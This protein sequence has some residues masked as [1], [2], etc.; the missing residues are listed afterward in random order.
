MIFQHYL[1]I[2]KVCDK[3]ESLASRKAIFAVKL[4]KFHSC[5][6]NILFQNFT[7][8]L[9]PSPLKLKQSVSVKLGKAHLVFE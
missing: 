3:I 5:D 6:V 8:Y 4:Q 2:S 7:L 1:D 9:Y